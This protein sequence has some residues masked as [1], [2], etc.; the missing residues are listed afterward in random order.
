LI[1]QWE[2][3]ELDILEQVSIKFYSILLSIIKTWIETHN[4]EEIRKEVGKQEREET[5]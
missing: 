2:Y 1:K 5:W 3:N 4:Q